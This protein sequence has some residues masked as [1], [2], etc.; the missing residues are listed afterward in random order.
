M[1]SGVTFDVHRLET[2]PLTDA[3]A[4]EKRPTSENLGTPGALLPDVR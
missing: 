2:S 3:A 1:P 4:K